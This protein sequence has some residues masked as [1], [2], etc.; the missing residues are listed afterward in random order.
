[1]TLSPT[2]TTSH[3]PMPWI[4]D[5]VPFHVIGEKEVFFPSPK[6]I[7]SPILCARVELA[8]PT[9]L[10]LLEFFEHALVREL[11]QVW[12]PSESQ[13]NQDCSSFFLPFPRSE[14]GRPGGSVG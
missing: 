12:V 7:S 13:E 8:F 1:M 14:A 10:D 4:K 3:Q 9:E 6:S 5:T 2:Q 11:S